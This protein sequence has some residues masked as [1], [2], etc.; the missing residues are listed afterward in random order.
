MQETDVSGTCTV[1]YSFP[2]PL[3][4][5]KSKFSCI[6]TDLPLSK[7]PNPILDTNVV[8]KRTT[9]YELD[10]SETRIKSIIA[11]EHHHMSINANEELGTF[12]TSKQTLNFVKTE[13]IPPLVGDFKQIF[14]QITHSQYI[15][16]SL[17]IKN[18]KENEENRESFAKTVGKVRDLLQNEHL[19]SVR[20]AKVFLQLVKVAR[21][22]HKDDVSKTLQSK[23]NKNVILQLYDVLGYAQ[24]PEIH[25]IVVKKL[26]FDRE[27]DLDNCERY[28]WALS[29]NSQP[30]I[31]IIEDLLN[32]FR[33]YENV[34]PKLKE[35]LILTIASMTQKLAKNFKNT[36]SVEKLASQVEETILNELDY[37]ESEDR[38][39]FYRALI[40]LQS[41][42]TVSHLIKSLKT[43]NSSRE[44]VFIWKTLHSFNTS[45]WSESV[46]QAARRTFLQLDRKY[47]SSA[48]TLALDVI[49]STQ[50]RNDNIINE[51]LE[52]LASNDR[53]YEVK[54]FLMQRLNML[55][56]DNAEFRNRLARLIAQN[57][58][59]NNY[60]TLAPRGASTAIKR[61]FFKGNSSH[62][63]LVSIQE[64]S[65]GFVK[66]GSVAV[67][68]EKNDQMNEFLNLGIYSGGLSSFL[69]SDSETNGD[70]TTLD[71]EQISVGMELTV[72]GTQIR[73][74]V[75]FTGQGELM[76]H[77]WSGTASERTPAYQVKPNSK[78]C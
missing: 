59:I 34:P 36:A 55:S 71:N 18:D 27:D 77:V 21:Q 76:G 39:T 48:R 70:E 47:D 67:I 51:L 72:L 16:S 44:I 1:S 37:A 4:V 33:N 69:T 62:A 23:K 11:K 25:Q 5:M 31:T 61:A 14:E 17:L 75:F 28:L 63:S 15:E 40:N 66:R 41:K 29:Y 8:S 19:G 30:E 49:L 9:I 60:S 13:Q 56:D 68:L 46:T 2:S 50:I 57:G 20:Q 6:S 12:I 45:W 22:A 10:S 24:T 35:T 65:K 42:S 64:M 7:H 54:Q 53:E 38:F 73:P 58:L 26:H 3:V 78:K 43:N 32:K 52:Y 74:F